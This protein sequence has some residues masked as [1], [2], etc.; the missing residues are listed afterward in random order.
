[1]AKKSDH[2]TIKKNL[3]KNGIS[4]CIKTPFENLKLKGAI[5]SGILYHNNRFDELLSV[6]NFNP[7]FQFS[8]RYLLVIL[9]T[10]FIK[11]TDRNQKNVM[12]RQ[13]FDSLAGWL[14]KDYP[15]ESLKMWEFV[16]EKKELEYYIETGSKESSLF[17]Y[18][19]MTQ[20]ME[21]SSFKNPKGIESMNETDRTAR[22]RV[23]YQSD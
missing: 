22:F 13:D 9:I 8:G 15:S 12:S 20:F 10:E 18:I 16:T 19:V 6:I 11:L 1:V 14:R 17:I 2:E 7:D 21:K 4:V 23:Y 5:H 3:M